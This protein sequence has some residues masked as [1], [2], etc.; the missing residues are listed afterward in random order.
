MSVSV[1]V[2]TYGDSSWE[3]RADRAEASIRPQ[4]DVGD[5]IVRHH[6]RGDDGPSPATLRAVRNEA[7]VYSSGDWLC[8]VDADD[9][10]EVGYL[11]A[12]RAAIRC[13]D[14]T[15]PCQD[16]DVCHYVDDGD[17]KAMVRPPR[18]LVPAVRYVDVNGMPTTASDGATIPNRTPP[19]P[20]W[21]VN[22]AVIGTLI[23]RGLFELVGGFH[24]WPI[25]EDWDLWLR[26]VA[27]GAELVDVPS[28]VYR[29]YV[30]PGGRNSYSARRRVAE[31]TYWAIRKQHDPAYR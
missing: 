19:R 8:F 23:P 6:V 13:S 10:L 1:I 2:A 4:L 9:E 20:L 22:V 26:A 3:E 5:V 27:V 14:P 21:E 16:G 24:E 12:M 18:L 30:N 29:A 28:A 15:C 25:Y 31:E 7:A 11:D 17:T